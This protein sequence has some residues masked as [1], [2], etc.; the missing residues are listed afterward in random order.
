MLDDLQLDSDRVSNHFKGLTMA[1]QVN[2]RLNSFNPL[3][4]QKCEVHPKWKW[5]LIFTT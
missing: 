2:M 4:A 5:L 3:H 1:L